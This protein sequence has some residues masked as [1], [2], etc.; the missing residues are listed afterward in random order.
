[1]LAFEPTP[2]I[3]ETL[4]C[5]VE[6]NGLQERVEVLRMALGEAEGTAGYSRAFRT[7]SE[8]DWRH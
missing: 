5:H 8:R 2:S 1:M 4:A 7:L 6:M 3:A